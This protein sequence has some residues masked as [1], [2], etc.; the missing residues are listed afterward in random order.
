MRISLFILTT[1]LA[2]GEKSSLGDGPGDKSDA[3]GL[4]GPWTLVT[5]T[6][7]DA[8]LLSAWSDGPVLRIV[9]GDLGGGEGIMLHGDADGLCIERQVTERALWWIH[10]TA[11][12]DWAAV[13]EDGTVLRSISGS[14]FRMDAPTD[15][16][17][18][19]VYVYGDSVIVAGGHVGAGQN[20][21]E[22]WRHDG[23]S[24]AP[25]AIGL[26][27]VLFKVWGHWF[28]GQDVSYRLD[29]A[30]D[31]LERFDVDG[32]LLTVRGFDDDDVWAVGGLVSPLVMHFE[33]DAFVPVDTTGLHTAINGV[34]TDDETGVWI[35]G[36]DGTTAQ[37]T[38]EGWTQPASPITTDHLHA[39]WRH[40]GATWWFGGDLFRTGNNHG[41]IIRYSEDGRVP[42]VSD[43]AD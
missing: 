1:A 21:G 27:E 40:N 17:L 39:V 12:G 5:D 25:L 30:T 43:C 42:E 8:V 32:R 28:V 13:G 35:A 38:D 20:D 31:T 41:T 36:N 19:G 16:T 2:C 29:M 23:E 18:F 4:D 14:R 22:I 26:P 34:Y 10:G 33:G 3:L 24:W 9:G 15:A 11:A 6:I 37:L 7:E